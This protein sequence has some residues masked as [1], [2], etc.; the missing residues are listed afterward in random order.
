MLDIGPSSERKITETERNPSYIGGSNRNYS[1]TIMQ[2]IKTILK[3]L[4]LEIPYDPAI[5][6]LRICSK[7]LKTSCYSDMGIP[8]FITAELIIEAVCAYHQTKET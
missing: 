3:E 1:I 2:G 6:L 4:N 5:T 8:I 7:E